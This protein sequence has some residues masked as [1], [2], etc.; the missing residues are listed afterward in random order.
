MPIDPKRSPQRAAFE[1]AQK[2]AE[3]A[4]KG[5]VAQKSSGKDAY[6]QY[7]SPGVNGF[8]MKGPKG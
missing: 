2:K 5:K 6:K 4:M 8:S 1:V 7:K 3:T